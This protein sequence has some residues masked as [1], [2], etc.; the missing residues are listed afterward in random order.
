MRTKIIMMLTL[1]SASAFIMPF[2][3]TAFAE[4]KPTLPKIKKPVPV[5]PR[6]IKASEK[7]HHEYIRS[8]DKNG[9]GVVDDRDRLLWL[10]EKHDVEPTV[11]V[12]TEN[13]DIVEVMDLDSDGN[14]DAAEMQ[15]FYS[16]YD[17]DGNGVL[18]EEE[19]T[20]ASD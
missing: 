4:H 9:D 3:H 8:H 16:K 12:S 5:I 15:Y 7:A 20:L 14:V 13:E 10:K 11:L 1:L 19:I 6:T 2:H 17:I 18:E